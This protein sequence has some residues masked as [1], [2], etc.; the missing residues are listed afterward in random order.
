MRAAL[1]DIQVALEKDPRNPAIYDSLGLIRLAT[2]DYEAAVRDLNQAC[3][4]PR[5]S[6][7]ARAPRRGLMARSGSSKTRSTISTAPQTS[8]P[9]PRMPGPACARSAA[10]PGLS[11]RRA[12]CTRALGLS[13]NYAPAFL[14]RGSPTFI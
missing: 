8:T 12:D 1:R 9:A 3:T 5:T 14:Q 7:R 11:R 6:S 4:S 13:Q 2:H 10:A